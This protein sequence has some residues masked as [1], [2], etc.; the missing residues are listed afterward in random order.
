MGLNRLGHGLSLGGGHRGALLSLVGNRSLLLVDHVSALDS[1]LVDEETLGHQL[2]HLVLVPHLVVFCLEVKWSL[3]LLSHLVPLL[4]YQLRDLS[5]RQL[6]VLAS[7]RLLIGVA[8][9]D[10]GSE[11]LL[12]LHDF[13][14]DYWLEQIF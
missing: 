3:L 6:G 14:A 8:E 9:E 13:V 11:W 4:T 10:E 2:L 1:V 7:E 12:W 5:D